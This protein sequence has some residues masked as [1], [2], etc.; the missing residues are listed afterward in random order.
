MLF[1]EIEVDEKGKRQKKKDKFIGI[2]EHLSK[3][4]LRTDR[5][6]N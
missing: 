5:Q 1:V 4:S 2:K 6:Y 3:P